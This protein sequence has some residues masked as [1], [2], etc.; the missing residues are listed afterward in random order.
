MCLKADLFKFAASGPDCNCSA[1]AHSRARDPMNSPRDQQC[2]P[3]CCWEVSV[4]HCGIDER[5]TAQI[6]Q[7]QRL[8]ELLQ[9][10]LLRSGLRMIKMN[11]SVGNMVMNFHPI[12]RSSA[13]LRMNNN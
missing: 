5:L 8:S 12:K 1:M 11:D 9:H 7:T 13:C 2:D 4:L 3:S 10:E 6:Y